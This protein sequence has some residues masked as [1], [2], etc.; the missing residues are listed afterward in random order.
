[1]HG[2]D[3]L[4]CALP[5]AIARTWLGVAALGLLACSSSAERPTEVV[6][7]AQSALIPLEPVTTV[8]PGAP[9]T[10]GA[11]CPHRRLPDQCGS[12]A[13]VELRASRG[14]KKWSWH[15]HENTED[16]HCLCQGIDFQIPATLPVTKGRAGWAWDKA[17]LSFRKAAGEVVECTYRG[18]GFP[19]G[20]GQGGDAYVLERCSRG[21]KAGQTA[22]SDWFELELDDG[23]PHG[24]EVEV[25]VRLG[26]PDVVGGVVQEQVFYSDD[27]RIPGAAL[28]V[29]RGSAPPFETFTL[30]SLSQVPPGTAL[31][32]GS[33]T[34]VGYGVDIHSDQTSNFVFTPVA[35]AACPRIELPYDPATLERLVGPGHESQLQGDQLL[36]LTNLDAG[37]GVL[38][39]AGPVTVNLAEHTISFCVEHLSFWVTTLST[40]RA[41]ISAASLD[42][43]GVSNVDLLT[44]GT[45]PLMTPDKNYTLTLK[46][47]NEG[48]GG[49]ST[50]FKLYAVDKAV[51]S[52]PLTPTSTATVNK[53]VPPAQ[54]PWKETIGPLSGLP[55]AGSGVGE[56]T[57]VITITAPRDPA[58]LNFCL[59]DATDAL[60]GLCFS[61]ETKAFGGGSA[62]VA[63]AEICDGKDNDLDNDIDEGLKR[64]LYR[65]ADGDGFGDPNSGAE[66]CPG[67]G[68]ITDNTD[69]DDNQSD[70]HV[71]GGYYPDCD[72]DGHGRDEECRPLWN[73]ESVPI[74]FVPPVK[75]CVPPPAPVSV[76]WSGGTAVV[77]YVTSSDDCDNYDSGNY[78]GNSEGCDYRDN[79]CN[80]SADDESRTVSYS[81]DQDSDGWCQ[82]GNTV[83][84]CD[85]APR[86]DMIKTSTCQSLGYFP[87]TNSDCNDANHWAN[88]TCGEVAETYSETFTL[89]GGPIGI[90]DY[91]QFHT[92]CNVG[93]HVSSC[94]AV[95]TSEKG[96]VSI[97]YCPIGAIG[98]DVTLRFGVEWWTDVAGYGVTYCAPND[99]YP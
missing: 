86:G 44:A 68:Y 83:L 72:G 10:R 18:N 87:Y 8:E 93:W 75:G 73:Q 28:H 32:G 15:D 30:T 23:H 33:T 41:S 35:G 11:T 34:S 29:P 47:K 81:Y 2:F 27:A 45:P 92:K 22:H 20:R 78:P 50:S 95:K 96:N 90:V 3:R 60:F 91:R 57:S 40:F 77:N 6:G 12:W 49:W 58:P 84:G 37:S 43:P 80:G 99:T 5:R 71:A 94:E 38:A 76:D 59:A 79:N 16:T 82:H 85:W 98:G 39:S 67:P 31:Q 24:D 26:A 55:A 17:E 13:G 74:V 56:V 63:T 62:N 51:Y 52:L 64:L 9:S 14:A 46:F 69:C 25:S 7:S 42:G 88:W 21:F 65:D 19:F 61:W 48:S 97:T 36:R 66:R 70:R 53:Y 54:S 1:M 89:N 4:A